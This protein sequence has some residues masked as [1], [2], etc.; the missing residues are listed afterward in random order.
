MHEHG[1]VCIHK[2]QKM[3]HS[4]SRRGNCHDSA[5]TEGVSRRLKRLRSR[6]QANLIREEEKQEVFDHI[7]ML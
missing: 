7:E 6:Q 2:C 1:L 4:M 5:V 3:G